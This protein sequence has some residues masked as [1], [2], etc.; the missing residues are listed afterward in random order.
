MLSE[1]LTGCY[2]YEPLS[3]LEDM[4]GN[5]VLDTRSEEA[6][7][8]LVRMCLRLR[9]WKRATIQEIIDSDWLQD[10]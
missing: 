8:V 7:E 4:E 2:R 3:S 1:L 10:D 9:P 6:E 5:E